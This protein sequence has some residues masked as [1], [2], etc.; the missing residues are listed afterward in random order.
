MWPPLLVASLVAS[1]FASLRLTAQTD[2]QQ[3][4]V[5]V[6]RSAD[7]VTVG[8]AFTVRIRIRAPKVATIRFPDV[9]ASADAIEPVDPRAVEDGPPGDLLDRTATYRF[10]AWDVGSRGP[11]FEPVTIT[12]AGQSRAI[13]VVVPPVFVRSLLPADSAGHEPRDARAPVPLPGRLWQFVFLGAIAVALLVIYWRRWRRM[14]RERAAATGTDAWQDVRAAWQALDALK[15][16]EA[17][18]PGR[19]VI[20]H[21]DV[22]RHYLARRFPPVALTLNGGEA[23]A[24]LADLDFP[25][26]VPRVADLLARDSE[27]RFA[28]AGIAP[29]EAVALAAEARDI[30]AQVQL[31]HEARLRAIERPPRPRRR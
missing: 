26:P 31:A 13:A 20:A 19:H 24:V 30:T 8:D 23:T 1:Q 17:G 29:D 2:V 3:A 21:V 18:E 6:T 5:D 14:R 15:L 27:L 4:L 25:V 9:P 7:T 12:V 16:D 22:L 11:V 28:H 10:V